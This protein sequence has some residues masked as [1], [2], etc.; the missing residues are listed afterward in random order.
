MLQQMDK[1]RRYAI[2]NRMADS[3]GPPGDLLHIRTGILRNSMF[4]DARTTPDTVIGVLGAGVG[5]AAVHE[6]GGTF[7]I[8]GHTQQRNIAFGRPTRA[9]T[10]TISPHSATYPQ[11]AFIK[12][13]LED[14][15]A[16]IIAALAG[17]AM[18]VLQ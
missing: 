4:A 10:V 9:Y 12:P 8:P 1:S 17:T 11:R 15:R 3:P 16:E 14:R 2:E 5:Y 13:S 18:K 7:S 6:K